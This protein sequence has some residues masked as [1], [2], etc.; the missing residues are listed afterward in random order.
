MRPKFRLEH[1]SDQTL[2]PT[3]ISHH[4][5]LQLA[6]KASLM[7]QFTSGAN[8]FRRVFVPKTIFWTFNANVYVFLRSEEKSS[9]FF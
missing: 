9:D 7:T 3:M 2:K 4:F 5:C 6:D 1:R 8:V